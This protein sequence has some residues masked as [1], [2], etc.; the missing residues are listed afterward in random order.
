M[1]KRERWP[2]LPGY[3]RIG[4]GQDARGELQDLIRRMGAGCWGG[5]RAGLRAQVSD[6]DRAEIA[7]HG[8]TAVVAGV[9]HFGGSASGHYGAM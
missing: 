3:G 4:A 9:A 6:S 8:N 1:A 7:T 5:D 2:D